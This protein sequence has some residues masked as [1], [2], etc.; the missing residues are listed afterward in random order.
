MYSIY[1]MIPTFFFSIDKIWS[2]VPGYSDPVFFM[3]LYFD[4]EFQKTKLS[5]NENP[6]ETKVG[7]NSI[8]LFGSQANFLQMKIVT[9][10]DGLVCY[11]CGNI[12]YCGSQTWSSW[13]IWVVNQTWSVQ[14]ANIFANCGSPSDDNIHE[15][16][17][18]TLIA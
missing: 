5:I 8:S 1:T 16:I 10:K 18:Q 12:H 17:R 4:H 2:K 15:T 11:H 3:F 9:Y 7:C 14:L 13:Q 6:V